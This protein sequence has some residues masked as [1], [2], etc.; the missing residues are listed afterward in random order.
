M[1]SG[2]RSDSTA[3]RWRSFKESAKFGAA[4]A[5]V[6]SVFSFHEGS[7]VSPTGPTVCA[8]GFESTEDEEEEEEEA[9]EGGGARARADW[10]ERDNATPDKQ[11]EEEVGALG[12]VA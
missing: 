12:S 9:R 6:G 3:V 10:D 4:G 2:V 5:E 7:F 11:D 1:A 8:A